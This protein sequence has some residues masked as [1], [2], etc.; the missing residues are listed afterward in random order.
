[1]QISIKMSCVYSCNTVN[2]NKKKIK[3]ER[4]KILLNIWKLFLI[5]PRNHSYHWQMS[6]YSTHFCCFILTLTYSC[7][8]IY[9]LK[10]IWK[11]CSLVS[12]NLRLDTKKIQEYQQKCV[13]QHGIYIHNMQ[14]LTL[15]YNLHAINFV[16]R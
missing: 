2:S 13:S 11:V 16:Y 14:I 15:F 3:R 12:C 10:F 9:Q 4:E 8:W 1:M 7:K 5:Q 6:K